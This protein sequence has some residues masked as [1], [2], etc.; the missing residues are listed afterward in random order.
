[1]MVV[2]PDALSPDQ[3][4]QCRQALAAAPWVDG[5][6]TAGHIA[7]S[8]KQNL[9][10]P[11]DHPTAVELA[12]LVLA[13]VSQHPRFVSAALPLK[14][15][16]PMFNCY[17][18]GDGHNDGNHYSHHY[19]NHVDNAIRVIPDTGE[20]LRTDLSCTL[21][22]SNP[23]EYQGGEL[24]IA[25]TYGTHSVKLP[26]GHAVVYPGTSLHHVTPVTQGARLAAVFWVQSFVRDDAQRG[27]L[28]DL[29]TA[30]QDL[31][32]Q[33]ADN[34]ALVTLTGVY[35]NLLRQWADT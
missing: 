3:V 2:I 26:A 11:A 29:D 5:R 8:A 28:F 30:I 20:R 7:A 34:A 22:L 31:T 25:D 24:S 17:R 19:G 15:L 12:N 6:A 14:V 21:F 33:A 35:H 16:P 10:L 18:G 4:R 1:M 9:Q 32:R 27:I 13:A 23:D